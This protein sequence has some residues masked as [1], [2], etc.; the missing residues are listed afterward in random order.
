MTE[1]ELKEAYLDSPNTL[2]ESEIDE[3]WKIVKERAL[4]TT[5]LEAK[6]KELNEKLDEIYKKVE[7]EIKTNS[8]TIQDQEEY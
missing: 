2:L 8:S 7:L 5:S 3:T 6:A 4:Y 1:Y